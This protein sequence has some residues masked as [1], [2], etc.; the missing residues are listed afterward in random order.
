MTDAV[1]PLAAF[2]LPRQQ[3][4]DEVAA[5][6]R[7]EVMSGVLRPGEFIR[8]ESV[9]QR[10]GVSVTPVREALLLLRGEDVV[11]LIPRR[12]FVVAPLSRVDVQDLFELQ[13]QLAG[14]LAARAVERMDDA[15]LAE[16][17]RIN[18]L[19]EQAV[20]QQASDQIE[21]LEYLFHRTVNVSADSR[22]LAYVLR[23]ATQYL[24]RRFFTAD[25]H[26]RRAVNRDHKR[27][28]K[29]L[30]AKD[31]DA[32]RSAM[33]AHVLDGQARLI[34]HLDEIGFWSPEASP[35]DKVPS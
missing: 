24:P 30:A 20:E 18:R 31:P 4:S 34:D 32:A 7:E 11:R 25:A 1:R 35:V 28:L 10:L 8:L 27:I 17:T 33:Q 3:L 16:L 22:K 5:R 13:S 23:S 29:A 6:L 12:G 2:A 9:A 26:W 14:Q 19:L 15:V 21:A